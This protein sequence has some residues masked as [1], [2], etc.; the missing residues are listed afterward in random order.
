[1]KDS[2]GTT[3]RWEICDMALDPQIVRRDKASKHL[4]Q[5]GE[6]Y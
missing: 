4:R 6:M 2:V 1:M 5:P 3:A